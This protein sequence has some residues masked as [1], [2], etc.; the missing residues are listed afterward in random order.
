MHESPPQA[1]E[2]DAVRYQ[3]T[4]AAWIRCGIAT[5]V[6]LALY[7]AFRL[8]AEWM[9]DPA[10][11]RILGLSQAR[12]G[13]HLGSFVVAYVAGLRMGRDAGYRKLPPA[14]FALAAMV[15]A[16]MVLSVH[17]RTPELLPFLDLALRSAVFGIMYLGVRQSGR[18]R[19]R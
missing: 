5:L 19:M 13:G 15:G 7:Q 3:Q 18:G 11:G 8:V 17:R 6:G 9:G 1:T 4:P 12:I 10:A 2:E 16:G 14:A